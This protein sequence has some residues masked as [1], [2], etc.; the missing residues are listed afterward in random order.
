MNVTLKNQKNSKLISSTS[1]WTYFYIDFQLN[2]LYDF[3]IT[4]LS[5]YTNIE[6]FN[7]T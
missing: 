6:K 4:T 1:L 5:E 2:N 3:T 7:I